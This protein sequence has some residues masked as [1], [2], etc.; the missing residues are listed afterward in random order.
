M[1]Q[2][3]RLQLDERRAAYATMSDDEKE[4]MKENMRLFRHPD[5]FKKLLHTANSVDA[6]DEVIAN[7]KRTN[8]TQSNHFQV[9][10]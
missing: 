7:M 4:T 9:S 5:F 3:F 2:L 1:F 10:N 6:D 8:P